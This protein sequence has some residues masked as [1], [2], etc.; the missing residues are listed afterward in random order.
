MLLLPLE[1]LSL[2][3]PALALRGMTV[4]PDPAELVAL[5][6]AR[7]VLAAGAGALWLE[8]KSLV[9]GAAAAFVPPTL[10]LL[11]TVLTPLT[12]AA[13]FAAAIRSVSFPTV[14]LSV[15]APFVEFTV[16]VLLEM[17]ES[18]L[19][20]ACTSL[21]ISLSDREAAGLLHPAT[22]KAISMKTA[23]TCLF[24]VIG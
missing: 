20:F 21:A 2:D 16:I 10:R 11:T 19:I 18:L 17:A 3:P 23:Q 4:R 1:A 7:S 5:R 14:P 24:I 12:V 22:I 13:S 6:P 8:G 9:A 15:T